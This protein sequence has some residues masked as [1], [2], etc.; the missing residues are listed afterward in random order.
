MGKI[1]LLAPARNS[2]FGIAAINCGADAVYI[3]ITNFSARQSVGN[4]INEIK[5]KTLLSYAHRFYVKVYVAINI[6]IF[7]NELLEAQ[8]LIKELYEMILLHNN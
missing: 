6:I 4:N 7:N 8:Q 5:T 3:G 1:E 2:D